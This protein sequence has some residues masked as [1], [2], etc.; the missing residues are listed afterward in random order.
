M[1]QAL[2]DVVVDSID[3]GTSSIEDLTK[4]IASLP[5]DA[6]AK[7]GPFADTANGLKEV[8][9]NSIGKVCAMTRSMNQQISGYA[10]NLIE[11]LKI[12]GKQAKSSQKPKTKAQK[13]A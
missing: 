3:K 8:Q 7:I 6:L 13:A 5:Y 2:K 9:E 4:S 1:F 10:D 11:K 12:N